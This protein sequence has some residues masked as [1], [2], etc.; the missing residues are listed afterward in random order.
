VEPFRLNFN[1]RRGADRYL[2]CDAYK[3]VTSGQ[4]ILPLREKYSV[5]FGFPFSHK[6]SIASST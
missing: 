6:R 2:S 4:K 5:I 3:G 1:C